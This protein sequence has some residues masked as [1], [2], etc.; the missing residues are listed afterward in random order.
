MSDGISGVGLSLFGQGCWALS[1][2]TRGKY[3]AEGFS[4]N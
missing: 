4:V 1:P 3:F 2:T